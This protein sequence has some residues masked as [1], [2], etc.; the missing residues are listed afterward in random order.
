MRAPAG[1]EDQ[2]PQVQAMLAKYVCSLRTEVR[3]EETPS[4]LPGLPPLLNAPKP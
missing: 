3:D 4:H 2:D 1:P